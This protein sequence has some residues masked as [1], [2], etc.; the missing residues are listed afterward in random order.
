ML[1][2]TGANGQLGRAVVEQLLKRV[3]A[4][5][6]GV[7]VREPEKAADLAERGVRVRA[8]DFG[9]PAGLADAFEGARRILVVSVNATGQTAVDQNGAAFEAAKKAGAERVLYTSHVG[10]NPD[11]PFLPMPDHAATE[12][13]LES[14]GL[15]FTSLRNGFYASTTLELL[16][17]AMVTGKLY[18]PEDGPVSWTTHADLAEA[19]AVL[20]TEDRFDGPTPP[21]TGSEA[22]DLAA[23]A[24]IASRVTGREIERVVATDEDFKSNLMEHAGVPE[25]QVDFLLGLFAASRQGEF[26]AVGP[27]LGEVLGRKPV[28]LEDFLKER[29]AG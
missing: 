22:L 4:E 21:L 7:S 13:V 16:G 24:E 17:H 27:A 25:E 2:V 14:A 26:S 11:S 29:L 20:L 3:P 12:K 18:A 6:V 28:A 5:Q 1:I 9:D 10:V 15:P 23:V 8:G 19:A